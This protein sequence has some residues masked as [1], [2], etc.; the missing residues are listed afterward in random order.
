MLPRAVFVRWLVLPELHI[1]FTFK[2]ALPVLAFKVEEGAN[3]VLGM[4]SEI[5]ILRNCTAFPRCGQFTM[6]FGRE[7]HEFCQQK[8]LMS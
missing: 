1:H 5:Q 8:I 7:G 3:M 2:R 4:Q 6:P